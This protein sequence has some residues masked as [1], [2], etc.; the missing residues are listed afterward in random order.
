MKV[1][2]L[3][4]HITVKKVKYDEESGTLEEKHERQ[5][6]IEGQDELYDEIEVRTEVKTE[7]KSWPIKKS[8]G[9]SFIFCLF[10]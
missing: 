3:V 8:F 2:N 9:K 4:Q 7:W 1:L 10:Y 5:W 6:S